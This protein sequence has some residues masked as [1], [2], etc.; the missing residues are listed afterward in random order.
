MRTLND[1]FSATRRGL[2]APGWS[3]GSENDDYRGKPFP[4]GSGTLIQAR[5]VAPHHKTMASCCF[6]GMRWVDLRSNRLV[7]SLTCVL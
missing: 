4:N 3:R 6:D 7:K 1:Q 5:A 2:R